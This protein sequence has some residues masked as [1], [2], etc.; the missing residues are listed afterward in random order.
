M[1]ILD[2]DL[3]NGKFL[4]TDYYPPPQ[5]CIIISLLH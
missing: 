1:Y 2:I 3:R 5:L 4:F